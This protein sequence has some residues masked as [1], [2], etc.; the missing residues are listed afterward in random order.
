MPISITGKSRCGQTLV[1]SNGF[2]PVRSD[3]SSA[4]ASVM[5]C[6]C[7]FHFGKSPFSFAPNRSSCVDSL[8]RQTTLESSTLVHCLSPCCVLTWISFHTL[9]PAVLLR[10]YVIVT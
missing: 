4:C 6:T 8:V 3:H 10:L 1:R 7:T 2:Q 5:I 9:T